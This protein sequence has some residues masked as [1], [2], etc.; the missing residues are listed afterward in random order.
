MN[1]WSQRGVI[2][3]MTQNTAAGLYADRLSA[4]KGHRRQHLQ[5]EEYEEALYRT[6]CQGIQTPQQMVEWSARKRRNTR[7]VSGNIRLQISICSLTYGVDHEDKHLRGRRGT[8]MVSTRS[9]N[10]RSCFIRLTRGTL[11][12]ERAER[13]K[14]KGEF[15]LSFVRLMLTSSSLNE[16]KSAWL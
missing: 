2:C 1:R 3:S 14:R 8:C 16:H 10:L 12:N 9:I 13:F 11:T 5:L 7:R 6:R 15:V 4:E